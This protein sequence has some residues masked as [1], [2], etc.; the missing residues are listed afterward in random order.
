MADEREFKGMGYITHSDSEFKKLECGHC[1]RSI[2]G[3]VVATYVAV[4]PYV[5]WI[6]CPVCS[7]GS[8]IDRD[9]KTYP[10]IPYGEKIN[11]LPKEVDAVYDEA[12]NSMSIGAL[13]GC[14]LVCRKILMHIAVDKC[15]G[16]EGDTFKNY[17]ELIEKAGYITPPMQNW[18]KHIKDKGNDATHKLQSPNKS[19]AENILNFTT[20]LLRLAYEMEYLSKQFAKPSSGESS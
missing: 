16:K 11:G 5:T 10:S 18:V 6:I 17:I 7:H 1:G 20:Q 9:E 3:H 19:E 15:G 12:R 14:E 4:A 8:V 2:S 13:T